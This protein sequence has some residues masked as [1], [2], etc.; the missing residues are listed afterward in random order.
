MNCLP[1]FKRKKK[2]E[3]KSDE[4][5]SDDK[6]DEELPVAQPKEDPLSKQSSAVKKPD[7]KKEHG[8]SDD[9]AG[10][11]DAAIVV[12]IDEPSTGAA[13]SFKYQELATATKNFKQEYLLGESGFGKVY[14][15]TLA[16]GKVVAVKQLK[17]LG[18]K[19]K[20]FI[21]QVNKW[22]DLQHP[23][24]VELIG[25]CAEDEYRIL[26]YEYIPMG[27]VI[28]HL[29]NGK[30][31]LDWITRMK[32][33]AGAA[34]ALEYLHEKVNP[35]VL[36]GNVRSTNVLLD[37]NFEAKVT[38][39]GLVNLE[40]SSG[41][42]VYKTVMGTVGCAPETEYSGEL[43]LNSH[44]Y[45]FGVILLELIAGRKALDTSR[46]SNEQNLVSWAQPYINDRRRFQELVDPMFKGVVHENSIHQ[47][48]EVA[49]KCLQHEWSVRPLISD[50]LRDLKMLTVAPPE[51]FTP[52]EVPTTVNFPPNKYP[53]SS[54]S[55]SSSDSDSEQ[56]FSIK[57]EPFNRPE[58]EPRAEPEPESESESE[59]ENE[60]ESEHEPEPEWESEHEPEPEWE[61][62]PE[63]EPDIESEPEPEPIIESEPEP[64]PEPEPDTESEPEPDTES[65]PEPDTKPDTESDN[66]PEPEPEPE[67]EL[68][69]GSVDSDSDSDSDSDTDLDPE[70]KS[71]LELLSKPE[72]VLEASI[73][74]PV[75]E[76][77]SNSEPIHEP[78][79]KTEPVIE[80][81]SK[82]EPVLEPVSNPEPVLEPVSKP[83]PS[84]SHKD[85][86]GSDHGS[87]GSSRSL[88]D[89]DAYS[90]EDFSDE[91]KGS[92]SILIN[93][94]SKARM[95]VKSTKKKVMFNPDSIKPSMKRANSSFSKKSF[96]KSKVDDQIV[97]KKSMRKSDSR[98]DDNSDIEFTD[99]SDDDE[100]APQRFK[101]TISRF[102]ADSRSYYEDESEHGSSSEGEK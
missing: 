9:N 63:P 6:E 5:K 97:K 55:S 53:S 93:S 37:K 96:N 64:D 99:E 21:E 67:P 86:S 65:E 54:S 46:P 102:S 73:P 60:W 2:Q 22:S 35:P 76:P 94:K 30:K 18:T 71:K 62:E 25:Y 101:S 87:N 90:E 32:I 34:E 12:V 81:V 23:N 14:K 3:K 70:Q 66:E 45:S 44:V 1:C 89:E 29:N 20:E 100:F 24:L 38:D 59:H 42:N 13:R 75:L 17:K 40:S 41:S 47:A 26:V 69:L 31:S 83:E 50:I 74:E 72:P 52:T 16:S 11:D 19:A 98:G 15:G 36:C 77:I 80:P 4:K 84:S 7:S 78:I 91:D 79:S 49:E 88:Y 33:A 57:I 56:E 10:V 68:E 82:P 27:S 28:D 85:E 92:T 39:Y 58:P 95:K 48:V 51:G 8:K 43:T 61:S